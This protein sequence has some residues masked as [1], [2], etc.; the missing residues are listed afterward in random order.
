MTKKERDKAIQLLKMAEQGQLKRQELLGDDGDEVI[1]VLNLNNLTQAER[2]EDIRQCRL[3]GVIPIA[4]NIG[5]AFTPLTEAEREAIQDAPQPYGMNREIM[6]ANAPDDPRISP[7]KPQAEQDTFR[8]S[9]NYHGYDS[10]NENS[11]LGRLT[12]PN[13]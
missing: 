10:D 4:L 8:P 5:Q 1:F 12:K 9:H 6:P 7:V 3:K 13:N 11:I 2:D